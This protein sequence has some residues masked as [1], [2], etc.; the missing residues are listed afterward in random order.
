MEPHITTARDQVAHVI[1]RAIQTGARGGNDTSTFTH[2]KVAAYIGT[3]V[4]LMNMT[5]GTDIPAARQRLRLLVR[6][7]RAGWSVEDRLNA[8]KL[9]QEA[10]VLVGQLLEL[11]Q[12][13]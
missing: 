2:G 13:D 3:A 12:A 8:A 1:G 6:D 4:D 7:L 9:G 5:Y 10:H 11:P